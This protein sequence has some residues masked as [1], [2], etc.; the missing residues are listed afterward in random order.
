MLL[1]TV[2]DTTW[3]DAGVRVELAAGTPCEI[4]DPAVVL[5]RD[6]HRLGLILIALEERRRSLHPGI[7]VM[8]AGRVRVIA[9]KGVQHG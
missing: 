3:F 5:S 7:A 1:L 9:A 8:L 6:A 4:V 2:H